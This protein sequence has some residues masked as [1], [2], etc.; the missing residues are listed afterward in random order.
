[1]TT[2]HHLINDVGQ[3]KNK[4]KRELKGAISRFPNLACLVPLVINSEDCG[5]VPLTLQATKTN[6]WNL[7][8]IYELANS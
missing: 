4:I 2:F 8:Q 1:M 7:S 5:D 3:L 6:V